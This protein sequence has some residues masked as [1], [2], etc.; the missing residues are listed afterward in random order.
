MCDRSAPVSYMMYGSA[1]LLPSI[2][3]LGSRQM[4]ATDSLESSSSVMLPQ[5]AAVLPRETAAND[6]II[7]LNIDRRLERVYSVV[8]RI[9][10]H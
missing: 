10:T 2:G 5:A 9:T 8:E 6:F 7:S 1:S 4:A 3:R